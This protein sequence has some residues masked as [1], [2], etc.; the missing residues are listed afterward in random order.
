MN[1]KSWK[2]IWWKASNRWRPYIQHSCSWI[3]VPFLPYCRDNALRF[4]CM[5]Y[6]WSIERNI[7]STFIIDLTAR[8]T[9]GFCGFYLLNFE[10]WI[11]HISRAK[12]ILQTLADQWYL[13]SIQPHKS[14]S[15][16]A[17]TNISVT[18]A[19]LEKLWKEQR[20]HNLIQH[21]QNKTP[22]TLM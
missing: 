3:R 21:L 20:L 17:E 16:L 1:K 4:F 13:S 7:S 2:V 11:Y 5:T 18:T 9:L 15:L 10:G 19:T 6:I 14:R 8:E 12:S 22:R